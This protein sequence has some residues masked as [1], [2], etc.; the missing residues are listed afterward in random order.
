[1]VASN[2]TRWLRSETW[3]W[4]E[5]K[6]ARTFL[7]P[8]IHIKREASRKISKNWGGWER[9]RQVVKDQKT[10]AGGKERGKSLKVKKARANEKERGLS[11]TKAGSMERA[12]CPIHIPSEDAP[13][14]I[15]IQ[16][17]AEISRSSK[18]AP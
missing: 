6:Q 18:G 12:A 2:V 3:V 11:G 15:Q 1:M 14:Q 8:Q 9:E 5:N 13:A 4:I 7:Q 17:L 16:E 10:R